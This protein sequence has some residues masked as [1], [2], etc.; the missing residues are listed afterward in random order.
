MI[1]Y[2]IK[3]GELTLKGGNRKGFEN[4]LR[5]N[6]SAMLKG[7]GAQVTNA[8]G[9]FF[10]RCDEGV[11]EKAEDA[12]DR[13][14]GIS[15][16]ARTRTTEKKPELVIAAAVE[17]GKSIRGKGMRTFK[18]EARRTDKSFPI[19][20]YQIRCLAGDAILKE[21][22]DLMVDVHKPEGVIEVEIRDKAYVFA[23]AH[24][25]RR[26]LPV[27]T[28]GRGLL[29]LSGGIDSPVAG[30]M[31]ASRG[32]ALDAV[33]F[34]AY[35]YTSD[36]ARGKAVK[37]AETVGRYTQGIM[38]FVTGFTQIQKRIKERA[39]E[40]WR[41]VLLRMAMME[42]AERLALSRGDKCLISGESL[43]QVA[44]QTIENIT[45]TQNRVKLP[46]LRPLIGMG[47]EEIIARA[48]KI[49]TYETSILPYEDCCVLFSPP[50]PVLRGNPGEALKIYGELDAESLIEEA[51][52]NAGIVKCSFPE[53]R[54][55]RE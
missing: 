26:G 16:W 9:R 38:L 43:S 35:P 48:E 13:L 20:S 24:T 37:L 41:T 17:E 55:V 33:Y 30:Y 21:V 45:C 52:E 27:G 25:G 1:L 19:D 51:L 42:C 28:A 4:I 18:V 2:L 11:S 54:G 36:E 14:M 8:N 53:N 46:V 49:G 22:P 44:S 34:H 50:H 39:P 5:R 47:K 23:M 15:G 29:L 3:P 32:M 40:A 10:L 7:T 31:M 6:L 12:L